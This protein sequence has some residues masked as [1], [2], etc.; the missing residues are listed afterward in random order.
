M[1]YKDLGMPDSHKGGKI[2]QEIYDNYHGTLYPNIMKNVNEYIIPT[3]KKEGRLHGGL[4]FYIHSNKPDKDVRTLNN[5]LNQYWSIITAITVQEMDYRINKKG[6]KK[7]I[8]QTSTIYDSIYGIVKQDAKTIKW[9]ND[10]IVEVITKDFVTDQAIK[11][12][13]SLGIANSWAEV[14]DNELP[15]NAT[16]KEIQEILTKLKKEN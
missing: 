8:Q 16:I 9:L 15:N 11:N 4:G 7:D 6:Y 2:T 13:A 5:F 1:E 12:E 14:D 3:I 10:N